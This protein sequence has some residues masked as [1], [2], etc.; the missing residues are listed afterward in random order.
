MSEAVTQLEGE[1]I[2]GIKAEGC[3]N[4]G[5]SVIKLAGGREFG[6]E[7]DP[8]FN[9]IGGGLNGGTEVDDGCVRVATA[10]EKIT[11]LALRF[12]EI[13]FELDG[14]FKLG[15][16]SGK[17][18]GPMEGYSKLVFEFWVVR[19]LVDGQSILDDRFFE[20]AGI[21]V[22]ISLSFRC[23]SLYKRLVLL[24][25]LLIGL[26]FKLGSGGIAK[27]PLCSG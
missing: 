17:I 1:G 7:I 27:T 6:R 24:L 26:N 21:E 20:R 15:T 16:F 25:Q 4:G 5:A 13:G 23:C 22:G 3:C 11:E 18:A 2:G 12:G 10:V 19:L 8:G 14:F 9:P